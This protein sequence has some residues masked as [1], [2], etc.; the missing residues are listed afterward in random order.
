MNV[1]FFRKKAFAV[2]IKSRIL[3]WDH[4]RLLKWVLY[5]TIN[6]LIRNR[7]KMKRHRHRGEYHIKTE[8]ETGDRRPEAKEYLSHKKLEDAKEISPLEPLEGSQLC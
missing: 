5:P 1:N 7:E 2:V 8:A 4:P 3:R 6:V